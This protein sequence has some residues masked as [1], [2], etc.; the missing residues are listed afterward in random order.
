MSAGTHP[1]YVLAS[2]RAF[3]YDLSSCSDQPF[4]EGNMAK[5]GPRHNLRPSSLRAGIIEAARVALIEE[6]YARASAREIAR[7][8]GC[9]QA[10][11][12]YHFTGMPEV[13]L[14]VLDEVSDRRM[15][16]YRGPMLA[17][18]TPQ[19][20][21]R[22]ARRILEEDVRSGDLRVLTELLSASRADPVLRAQV[23]LRI[24]RWQELVTEVA[25]RFTPSPL[26]T[27]VKP[28]VVAHCVVAGVLGLELLRELRGDGP[29]TRDLMVGLHHVSQL[30]AARTGTA[31]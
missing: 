18:R 25:R 17:A 23:A 14:A 4:R 31:P 12:F 26:R 6:G 19:Q 29:T 11:L 15:E 21:T 22:L 16:D 8:A 20:L 27:L 10:S 24:G 13:L 30:G 3:R 7:R 9:S 2:G 5:S 28:E 1:A